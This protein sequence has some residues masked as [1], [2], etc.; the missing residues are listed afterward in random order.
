[1][2]DG[3]VHGVG[4][5]TIVIGCDYRLFLSEA[6]FGFPY[7]WPKQYEATLLAFCFF[8]LI[9]VFEHETDRNEVLK[10]MEK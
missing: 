8:W 1:M 6:K 2:G 10:V 5:W 7:R 9:M 4:G 3:F